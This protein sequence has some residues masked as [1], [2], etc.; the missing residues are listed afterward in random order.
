MADNIK[1]ATARG[2]TYL[3]GHDANNKGGRFPVNLPVF[4]DLPT[5]ST[6][7]W[8]KA[9]ANVR[10]A[11]GRA[12]VMVIGDSIPTGFGAGTGYAGSRAK[13]YPKML[14]SG[15]SALGV[16]AL[17]ENI[18]GEANQGAAGY[19]SYDP[20]ATGMSNAGTDWGYDATRPTTG[21]FMFRR[22]ATAGTAFAFTPSV[23]VDTFVVTVFRYSSGGGTCSVTINGGAPATG[24]STLS[25]VWN[26]TANDMA[27]TTFTSASAAVQA[28]AL[29]KTNASPFHI[30]SMYAYN[31][32]TKAVDIINCGWPGSTS[33][34]WNDSSLAHSPK[35]MIAIMDPDL[36]I[37]SVG[38]NDWNGAS[39][40]VTLATSITNVTALVAA[41][42]ATGADALIVGPPQSNPAGANLAAAA[43]Q[44]TYI[45]AYR[46]IARTSGCM[47]VNWYDRMG[48]WAA[49]NT[50]GEFYDNVH[51]N[52]YAHSD[53]GSMLANVLLNC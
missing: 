21:K 38:S 9:L 5:V 6:R 49:A 25:A 41:A 48:T 28:I 4:N 2:L 19:N 27:T 3:I 43:V 31:S 35:S 10:T 20:R 33:T 22:D 32:A 7:K 46:E 47:F 1:N 17:C 45:D 16:P 44:Q 42:Q 12:K 29:T 26:G 53:F 37:I 39:P 30:N 11:Q 40:T 52:W 50:N 8:R 23:A 14:A 18:A 13:A 36:V 51:P 24:G 34:D 15:L